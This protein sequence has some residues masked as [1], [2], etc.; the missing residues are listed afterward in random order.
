MVLLLLSS[1]CSLAETCP[2]GQAMRNDGV[3]VSLPAGDGLV[4]ESLCDD[5]LDN[6]SDGFSD[7]DDQDC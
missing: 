5:G 4:G 2:E 1:G 3:C 7:C 6:D